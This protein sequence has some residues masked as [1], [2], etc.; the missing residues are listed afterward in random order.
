MS[1]YMDVTME[2][3]ADA[4]GRRARRAFDRVG[5][6][7]DA[8][9]PN[10]LAGTVRAR[11]VD[12]QLVVEWKPSNRPGATDVA[13]RASA[14]GH[15]GR[16]ADSA[17]SAWVDAYSETGD[18]PDA[19]PRRGTFRPALWIGLACAVLAAGAFLLLRR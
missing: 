11:G 18:M 9:S 7:R 8:A 14:S 5:K 15:S 17:M 1:R 3:E 2:G 12:I 19:G 4:V 13:L 6:V 16:A 10:R